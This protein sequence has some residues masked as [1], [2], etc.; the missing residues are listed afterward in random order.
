MCHVG[1]KILDPRLQRHVRFAAEKLMSPLLLAAFYDLCLILVALFFGA[2]FD[3]FVGFA[4]A[5]LKIERGV[6]EA[7]ERVTVDAPGGD[8]AHLLA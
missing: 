3:P 5:R 8:P 7:G 4:V 6:L 1:I 2:R